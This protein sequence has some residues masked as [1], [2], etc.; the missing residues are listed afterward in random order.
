M[1]LVFLER[2]KAEHTKWISFVIKSLNLYL[3]I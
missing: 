2:L 3:D 1:M